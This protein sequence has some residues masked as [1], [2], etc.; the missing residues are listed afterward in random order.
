MTLEAGVI[1]AVS[2]L[3]DPLTHLNLDYPDHKVS[4]CIIADRLEK[5]GKVLYCDQGLTM[6]KIK[7]S[8]FRHLGRVDYTKRLFD[9]RDAVEKMRQ[10]KRKE[11]D[12]K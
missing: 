4:L 12:T 11:G 10:S 7:Q 9:M 5:G 6:V 1:E 2:G 3:I 8:A